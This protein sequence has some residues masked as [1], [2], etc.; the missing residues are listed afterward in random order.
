M[1]KASDQYIPESLD[2]LLTTVRTTFRDG[3][4]KQLQADGKNRT[5][6]EH[7]QAFQERLD[8]LM[9][10][11]EKALGE[12]YEGEGKSFGLT[13]L[14][15]K[16]IA[17]AIYAAQKKQGEQWNGKITVGN[18][19][20][21]PS[22]RAKEFVIRRA[23]EI[24]NQQFN[25]A[26]EVA[27]SFGDEAQIDQ[28]QTHLE[29]EKNIIRERNG[30]FSAII[31]VIAKYKNAAVKYADEVGEF[32]GH[33]RVAMAADAAKV[34]QKVRN[35]VIAAH[36]LAELQEQY[37]NA[38]IKD[39]KLKQQIDAGK[40]ALS[41]G[42]DGDNTII[43]LEK[44]AVNAYNQL[45]KDS[46]DSNAPYKNEDK[47]AQTKE[48]F[49]YYVHK[50]IDDLFTDPTFKN[51][52]KSGASSVKSPL[53]DFA[54]ENRIIK[55]ADLAIDLQGISARDGGAA[56]N[57]SFD[58]MLGGVKENIGSWAATIGGLTAA[59]IG[60]FGMNEQTPT[61]DGNSTE[62]KKSFWGK[63]SIAV[64]FVASGIGVLALVGDHKG[65]NGGM[66]DKAKGALGR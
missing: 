53:S 30:D 38:K 41:G 55:Y 32:S 66:L 8:R 13:G 12:A 45:I 46:T 43:G 59:G 57:K 50:A 36:S 35:A 16:E 49:D 42:K 64:G 51:A 5:Q 31:N 20:M 65:I 37:D 15:A 1:G 21:L 24:A 14:Q 26:K 62:E 19:S 47:N 63:V 60:M 33:T 22:T 9:Q 6:E 28:M 2:N 39:P 3:I 11:T 27:K 58:K 7:N 25:A 40:L 23:E 54:R 34:A 4:E 56:T 29:D 61:P 52:W 48:A 10:A 18:L 44:E 17:N